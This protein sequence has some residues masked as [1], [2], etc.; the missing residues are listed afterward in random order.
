MAAVVVTVIGSYAVGL[1]LRVDQFPVAGETRIGS[2]FEA[3]P[4][5]KGSNQAI[6]AARLGADVALVAAL[7]TDRYGDEA[8][9]LFE[10]E[11]VSTDFV[12]RLPDYPTGVG[13]IIVDADGENRIIIDPGANAHLTPRNVEAAGAR[14]RRSGVVIAQLEIPLDIALLALRQARAAGAITML[15]PAPA[16]RITGPRLA[17]IDVLTPNESELRI[18]CGRAVDD[19]GDPLEDSRTLLS[20]GVG[21]VVLTRGAAGATIVTRDHSVDVPSPPV[22]VVDTTGAGDAFSATLAVHLASGDAMDVAVRHA[23]SAGALACTRFGVVPSL[24]Y[25]STVA[26]LVRSTLAH[27]SIATRTGVPGG[28][29]SG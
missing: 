1:T 14:I 20:A 8:I 21:T 5:G 26:A 3:G 2:A 12:V 13:F 27:P 18:L 24:P 28:L 11:G 6:Q 25:A 29:D 22:D 15:N 4:G 19:A 16:Q 7:G 17:G 23:T 10:R 9:A